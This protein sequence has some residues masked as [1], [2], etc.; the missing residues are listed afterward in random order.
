MKE[1]NDIYNIIYKI[2]EEKSFEK[3]N[4]LLK[5]IDL[6]DFYTSVQCGDKKYYC[7]H[8]G[9][10]NEYLEN[11]FN[12]NDYDDINY[13]EHLYFN[14]NEEPII[15]YQ[16]IGHT[17]VTHIDLNNNFIFIDTHSTYRDGTP[18]GDKSYLGWINNKFVILN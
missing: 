10:T 3:I 18:F 2:I 8:A 12:Q 7:S 16:I 13:E 11:V 14:E 6:F 9:F 17:P 15:P 1:K 4:I 5:N